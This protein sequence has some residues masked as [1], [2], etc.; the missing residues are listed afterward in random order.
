MK[1]IAIN[2]VYINGKFYHPRSIYKSIVFCESIRSRRLC[3][4][5][6]D[7]LEALKLL[8]DKC[9]KSYFC[10]GLVVE[11]LK[12]HKNGKIGSDHQQIKGRKVSN[13][14]IQTTIF[15]NL[16]KLTERE[17]QLNQ[18]VTVTYKRPQTI[19]ILLTNYKILAH[20]VSNEE[21]ISFP[22]GNVCFAKMEW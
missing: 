5:D 18:N 7:Y 11:M 13:I 20:E 17:K 6:C 12:K 10:K 22:C 14:S 9:I 8:K 1:P 19:A 2:R 15:R 16:L 21:G 4:R 3:E